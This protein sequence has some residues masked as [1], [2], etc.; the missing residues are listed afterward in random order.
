MKERGVWAWNLVKLSL[1]IFVLLFVFI[2]IYFG[3]GEEC[4]RQNIRWSARL[5]FI[6]FCFAF[7][8]VCVSKFSIS[9]LDTS[10]FNILLFSWRFIWDLD[11]LD[12]P[13]ARGSYGK[14]GN[15]GS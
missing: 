11:S 9:L 14:L 7:A 12:Y 1:G 4:F 6:F 5:S 15:F 8:W 13:A 10:K 2:F 3:A